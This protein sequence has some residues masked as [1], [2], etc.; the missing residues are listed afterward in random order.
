[1]A[2]A[3]AATAARALRGTARTDRAGYDR[4]SERPTT[5]FDRIGKKATSQAQI[6]SAVKVLWTLDQ[7]QRRDGNDRCHLQDH[8]KGKKRLISTGRDNANS[9]PSTNAPR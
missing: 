2:T 8:C 3:N 4:L 5:V 1:M 7:D 6:K 9:A